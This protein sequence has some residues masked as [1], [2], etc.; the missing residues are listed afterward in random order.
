VAIVGYCGTLDS[1]EFFICLRGLS[2][3]DAQDSVFNEVVGGMDT[4]N[5]IAASADVAGHLELIITINSV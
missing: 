2:R 4:L 3:L 1:H 5:D